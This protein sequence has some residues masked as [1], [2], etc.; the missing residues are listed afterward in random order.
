M[1]VYNLRPYSLPFLMAQIF[2]PSP[3]TVRNCSHCCN[4]GRLYRGTCL[5]GSA[6]TGR[7]LSS[8]LKLIRF[9]TVVLSAIL[10]SWD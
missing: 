6:I 1:S 5:M 10:L 4:V 3:F 8:P 7:E 9:I 2:F